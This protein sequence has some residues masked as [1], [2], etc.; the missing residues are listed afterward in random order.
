MS[1]GRAVRVA[2]AAAVL[3]VA[4]VGCTWPGD[5]Q[6]PDATQEPLPAV[7]TA[8]AAD[9]AVVDQADPAEAAAAASAAFFASSPVAVLAGPDL[10]DQVA[11]ASIAVALGVPM[12]LGDAATDA[13]GSTDD[14]GSTDAPEAEPSASP[15]AT[16][17]AGAPAAPAGAELDRLGA[18]WA[19]TVG[20]AAPGGDITTV[21]VD[22]A[23]PDAAAAALGIVL[24]AAP[25]DGDPLDAV[26]ALDPGG[27]ALLAEPGT[28]ASPAPT[29]TDDAGAPPTLPDVTR[30]APLDTTTLVAIDDDAQLPAVANARASGASVALLPRTTRD[31]SRQVR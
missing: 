18:T 3:A 15:D 24:E 30:A 23:D 28:P 29:A 7:Q 2:G 11:A 1:G 25:V 26:A 6:V 12:L 31:C 22:P 9:V 20:A 14:A 8:S 5:E 16:A 17:D 4:L 27:S 10:D 21:D 19:V 13:A